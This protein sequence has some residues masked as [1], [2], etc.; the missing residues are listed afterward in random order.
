VPVAL[1]CSRLEDMMFR[2]LISDIGRKV[3]VNVFV[4]YLVSTTCWENYV[5]IV[6]GQ[7]VT[8]LHQGLASSNFW[9]AGLCVT[10]RRFSGRS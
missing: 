4:L 8:C 5:Y 10:N 3:I 7:D 9:V 2:C 6:V 1:S